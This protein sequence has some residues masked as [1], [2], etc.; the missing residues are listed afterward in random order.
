[1]HGST[2]PAS[3]RSRRRRARAVSRIV[4]TAR[5]A[6]LGSNNLP[7]NQVTSEW[8]TQSWT[9]FL[10]GMGQ[11][12]KPEQLKQL[13]NAYHFTGTANGEVAMR[14]YPAGDS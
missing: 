13:D 10:S 8:N 4:D 2:S 11:T 5:I 3:R 9:H 14:W 6:W 1:M 7:T 12:L